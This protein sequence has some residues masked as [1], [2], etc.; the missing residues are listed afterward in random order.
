MK[1]Y[2]FTDYEGS[3]TVV[4][5]DIIYNESG[6]P[7]VYCS[8]HVSELR[9]LAENKDYNLLVVESEVGDDVMMLMSCNIAEDPIFSVYNVS[10][11]Y[12]GAEEGGWYYDFYSY[13]EEIDR[14]NQDYFD[15]SNLRVFPE[16]IKGEN[17]TKNRPY[18]C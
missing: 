10:R 14:N 1:T 17:E 18:Y 2:I 11:E 16:I 5:A 6:E 9:N 7:L 12:G 8:E 3:K 15:S 4:H 13:F